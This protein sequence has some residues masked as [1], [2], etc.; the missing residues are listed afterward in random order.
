MLKIFTTQLMGLLKRIDE[1]E[2]FT[3][4]DGARILAQAAVG[5]GSIFIY[6][7]GEMEAVTLEATV[8]EEPLPYA[9][10]FTS[11]DELTSVDRVLLVSRF[12]TNETVIEMAKQLQEKGISTVSIGAVPKEIERESV[13][14][15]TDVHIDT[16]LLKALIPGED[17]MR[18]GF[19]AVITALYAY[20]GL[21]FTMKEMVEE[22]E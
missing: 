12:S 19:P 5:D 17:G 13:H 22:Y 8:S 2:E 16:K 9:K 20:Y 10:P 4:E 18:F 1:K 3:I 21:A 6:G 11:F 15:L 14:T 7:A